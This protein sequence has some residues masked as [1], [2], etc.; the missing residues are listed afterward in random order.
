MHVVDDALPGGNVLRR[1]HAGTPGRNAGVGCDA[2]HFGE[3]EPRAAMGAAAQMNEVVVV[4]RAVA[5]GVLRHRRHHDAILERDAA[6]RER[7]E[8]RRYADV[9]ARGRAPSANQVSR[10]A[11]NAGS[12]TRRFSCEMRWLRVSR[13]YAN[14]S[15]SNAVYRLTF[16]NHSVELRAAFWIFSTSTER[17]ASYPA[18]AVARSPGA[19]NARA[20]AIASS[21]ASLVPEPTEKCAV[22]AASPMRTTGT[23][24]P[25][26]TFQCTQVRHTTRGKRIQIADPRRCAGVR[27]QCVA[28][29]PRREQPFAV[30]NPFLLRHRLEAGRAPGFF[31]RFD[32]ER[33][34]IAVV[35]IRVR[36]EPAVRRF[37]ERERE[38]GK[39]LLRAEPDEAAMPQVHVGREA[40]RRNARECGC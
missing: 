36:L 14:C 16:S 20:S 30:G 35:L 22:C 5:A 12:R 40:R 33:R 13:L 11:T 28:A 23:R 25:S 32:D 4:G 31:G 6:Q 39:P 27:H 19:C 26:M 17:S 3:H 34:R 9:S 15:A 18:S 7:R 29:E 2:H 10:F 1:V 21:S 37:D 24:R 8:H 38:R